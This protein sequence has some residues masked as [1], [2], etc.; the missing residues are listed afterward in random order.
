VAQTS[1]ALTVEHVAHPVAH[2]VH[3]NPFNLKPALH[4]RQVVV[5]SALNLAQPPPAPVYAA[6]ST[7]VEVYVS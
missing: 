5:V 6:A 1:A 4:A 7:H 3:T 2:A